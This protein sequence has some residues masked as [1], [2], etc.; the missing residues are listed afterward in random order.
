MFDINFRI[1][2]VINENYKDQ[3]IANS[4]SEQP[5]WYSYK[6]FRTLDPN[7][8]TIFN[9]G[10]DA[11]QTMKEHAEREAMLHLM[12]D[13]YRYSLELRKLPYSSWCPAKIH[14]QVDHLASI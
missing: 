12:L 10:E 13:F 9:S 6:D 7:D 8:A 2:F 11:I 1:H 14:Y 4:I 5:F 3:N